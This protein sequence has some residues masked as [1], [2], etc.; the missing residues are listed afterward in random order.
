MKL[1]TVNRRLSARS[2]T[3]NN[4]SKEEQ[5]KCGRRL[6]PFPILIT[7]NGLVNCLNGLFFL[8]NL[9]R[10]CRINNVAF[11]TNR[12]R[13][14]C[15]TSTRGLIPTVMFLGRFRRFFLLRRFFRFNQ[16]FATKSARR[17]S[18]MMF[19][20]IR[21]TSMSYAKCR[22]TV[23]AIRHITRLVMMEVGLAMDIRRSYLVRRPS[24]FRRAGRFLHIAFDTYMKGVNHSSFLRFLFSTLRIVRSGNAIGVR[25]TR[26]SL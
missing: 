22:T 3:R 23:V 21:R 25:F 15:H 10:V 20:G 19:R 11:I 13:I 1:R 18:I 24:F 26:V 2:L 17:R 12:I 14:T 9:Q 8:R 16:I 7:I 6:C 5:A 4:F